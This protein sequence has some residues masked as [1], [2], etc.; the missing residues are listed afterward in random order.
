M[1]LMALSALVLATAA[2]NVDS[3]ENQLENSIRVSLS[4]G[5]TVQEVNLTE[6]DDGNMTGYAV[7]EDGEGR[8]GRLGCTAHK[9]DDAGNYNWRCEP[10]NGE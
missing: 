1:R 2:C 10:V 7:V 6:Q 4:N 5:S 9:T 3:A 8:S